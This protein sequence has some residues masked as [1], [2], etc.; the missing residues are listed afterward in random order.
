MNNNINL[1]KEVG[2]SNRQEQKKKNQWNRKSRHNRNNQRIKLK[3]RKIFGKIK[4]GKK[5]KGKHK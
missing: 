2:G 5:T 3:T 1:K 4:E